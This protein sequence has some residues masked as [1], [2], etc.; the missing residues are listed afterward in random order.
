MLKFLGSTG[1]FCILLT[2]QDV[3]AVRLQLSGRTRSSDFSRRETLS[4]F[5]GLN[6]SQ[7]MAYST[8]LTLNNKIFSMRK[9]TPANAPIFSH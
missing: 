5:S 4:G 6:D 8:N 9:L 1:L 3:R 2:L 7:S